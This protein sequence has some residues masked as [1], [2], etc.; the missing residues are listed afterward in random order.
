MMKGGYPK[1][2]LQ[3]EIF[4]LLDFLKTFHLDVLEALKI[5]FRTEFQ[6]KVICSH[7]SIRFEIAKFA[8][9]NLIYVDEVPLHQSKTIDLTCY[10]L[11]RS[12]VIHS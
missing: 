6:I 5:S 9:Y 7:P 3:P 8:F 11:Y 4:K 1:P 10:L 12:K 2:T